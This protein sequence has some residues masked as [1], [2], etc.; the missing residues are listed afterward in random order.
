MLAADI[1]PTDPS[2]IPIDPSTSRVPLD[3]ATVHAILST[4]VLEHVADVRKPTSA[5]PTAFSSP[6][7][8]SS[9]PPTAHSSSTAT[10][11]TS[12]AGPSTASATNYNKLA[13]PSSLSNPN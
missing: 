13:S 9:A 7:A 1:A 4:Q 5:K 8:S 11:P 3:N 2:V 6:A 12:A 10:L